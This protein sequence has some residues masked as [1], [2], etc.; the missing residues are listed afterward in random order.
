[1]EQ[2]TVNYIIGIDLGINNV[3]W[4]VIETTTNEIIN[5]GVACFS[6][7]ESAADRRGIRSSRRIRKRARHRIER[8]ATLF[9][10][11]GLPTN[12][13]SNP[14]MI[15][16]RIKGLRE[17]I[18][19]SEIVNICYFFAIHR[20]YIPFSDEQ[21][22]EL[23][24]NS[25]RSLK[26][27][28]YPCEYI[29]QFI[30]CNG[31]YRG[32]LTNILCKDNERE[33]VD[34]LKTNQ[35]YYSVLSDDL[36]DKIMSIIK[37]KRKFF[38]GPGLP[39]INALSKYGRYRTSVDLDKY[40]LDHNYNKYLYERLIGKCD[41]LL[42]EVKA[43]KYCYDAEMFN[44]LND[45]I[46]MRILDITK[47][48][49][50]KKHFVIIN[51]T[52]E[53]PYEGKFSKEGI[54]AIKDYIINA[55]VVKFNSVISTILGC[56]E[57]NINGYRINKENK[58][59]ISKFEKYK[60]IAK[61]FK[62]KGLRP[63]WLFSDNKDTYN[64][65]IEI[66]TVIP[67][68]QQLEE[69]INLKLNNCISK[70]EIEVLK[71]VK[72]SIK[73]LKYH[74]LSKKLLSQVIMK[75]DKYD[76]QYNYSQLLKIE[77]FK[78]EK[79]EYLINNYTNRIT[80]PYFIN[81]KFVNE[82]IT[83]GQVKKSLRKAINIINSLIKQY[84]SYPEIIAIESTK[85]ILTGEQKKE[86]EKFQARQEKIRKNAIE[87]LEKNDLTNSNINIE[88]M[89]LYLETSG[90]CIYCGK[91]IGIQEMLNMEVEHILPISKCFD[92]SFSNKV[93]SCRDCNRI[94]SDRSAYQYI[95]SKYNNVETYLSRVKE[96]IK[97]DFKKQNLLFSDDVNK[98]DIRFIHRNLNDTAFASRALIEEIKKFNLFLERRNGCH[99]DTLST[100]GQITT[101]MRRQF[102]LSEKNRTF[103][104]HHAEDATIIAMI[105]NSYIGRNLVK[106]QND[107]RM[108]KRKPL[109]INLLDDC[110][111]IKVKNIDVLK[112][113][114]NDNTKFSFE[115]HKNPI[116][117]FSDMNTRKYI[118]VESD[119]YII[120]NI[121]NI[122]DLDAKQYNKLKIMLN[123]QSKTRLLCEKMDKKLFCMLKEI[124]NTYVN[125]KNPFLDYIKFANGQENSNNSIDY[126]KFGI[127]KNPNDKKSPI[128][129]KLRFYEPCTN[130]YLYSNRT[131]KKKN[132]YYEFTNNIPK[133]STMIGLDSIKQVCVDVYY[134][135]KKNRFVFVPI[136]ALS[137]KNNKIDVN[138]KNYKETYNRLVGKNQV[139]YIC[140]LYNG[141][142]VKIN[143]K[144]GIEAEGTYSGYDKTNKCLTINCYGFTLKKETFV[145]SDRRIRIYHMDILGNFKKALD[146]NDIL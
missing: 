68:S 117:E 26:D 92:D 50:E 18:S 135:V 45:F 7:S 144:N 108:W 89:M 33:L 51:S 19:L 71:V 134:D 6:T 73:D 138:E 38:E 20:G 142:Y 93:C 100:P 87:E 90:H 106:Y 28:E 146:T 78:K 75:M 77:E 114:N 46:N 139:K 70:D 104:Y 121:D 83:N 67:D 101:K 54:F 84:K 115:V 145:A 94:K 53:N 91:S 64:K 13:I 96:L 95:L 116:R 86:V 125:S 41:V 127:R 105:A 74:S 63:E 42:N 1:M 12:R 47:I 57:S 22:K 29:K 3:G 88:K 137:Y 21:D 60:Y 58:P 4:S 143:K 59:E 31:K 110:K 24:C 11:Y 133:Q 136:A 122:Y 69:M 49:L 111:R 62:E 48:P 32:E 25:F 109:D 65:V 72:D 81:D 23:K 37:S 118:K 56:D 40:N 129:K 34:I 10:E 98:F 82:I 141:T 44:F 43:P 99:I 61:K 85:E 97:D 17:Q 131:P 36:I 102:G 14:N 103:Q 140:R 120:N 126:N 66:L 80:E 15:D 130:P 27:G 5:Y 8:L 52:K 132:Q 128:I 107:A 119:F 16:T 55:P 30:E 123:S 76:Y 9:N 35:S 112:N 2:K 113:I 79:N 39:K 124:F